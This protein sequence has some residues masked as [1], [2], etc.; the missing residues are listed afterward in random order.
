MNEKLKVCFICLLFCLLGFTTNNEL[1]QSSAPSE[2]DFIGEW[3]FVKAEYLEKSSPST[4]YKVKYEIDKAEG[5]EKLPGC[6]HQA[7]KRLSIGE[8]A[9]VVCPFSTYIG[10]Y[11]IATLQNPEGEKYFLTI[12]CEPEELFEESPV[13]GMI[14]NILALHYWIEKIDDD[15]IAILLEE[16]CNENLVAKHS[17]VRCILKK[18]I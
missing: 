16:I 12:G 3:E 7:V 15:T 1:Q 17:A 5:L 9:Q 8:I 2:L 18:Q 10:R 6:L 11:F 14:F 4:N 13:E